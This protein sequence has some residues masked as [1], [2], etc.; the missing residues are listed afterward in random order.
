MN[1]DK[2]LNYL[3]YVVDCRGLRCRLYINTRSGGISI[4]MVVWRV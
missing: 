2:G 1:V 4:K 3:E